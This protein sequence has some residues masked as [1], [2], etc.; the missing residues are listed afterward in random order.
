V[1]PAGSQREVWLILVHPIAAERGKEEDQSNSKMT[2][3][4]IEGRGGVRSEG[5]STETRLPKGL[6]LRAVQ[7]EC[8]RRRASHLDLSKKTKKYPQIFHLNLTD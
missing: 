4:N 7:E 6:P 8:R 3:A 5:C 2:I 1:L